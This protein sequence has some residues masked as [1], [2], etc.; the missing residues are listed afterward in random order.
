[1]ALDPIT[2]VVYLPTAEAEPKKPGSRRATYKPGTF[3]L[4]VA[5]PAK[6]R[7]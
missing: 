4:L 7:E 1:M 3:G 2:H 5:A 6:S